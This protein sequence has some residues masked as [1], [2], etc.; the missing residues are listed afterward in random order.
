MAPT[1][2]AAMREAIT[3][4][5]R[6]QGGGQLAA[7]VPRRYVAQLEMATLLRIN[8]GVAR[9]GFRTGFA[10]MDYLLGQFRVASRH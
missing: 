6:N 1:T 7:K 2:A 3:A 4:S 10:S 5:N 9:F 8:A